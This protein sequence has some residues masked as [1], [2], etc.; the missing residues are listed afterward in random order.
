MTYNDGT[1]FQKKG[2]ALISQESIRLEALKKQ[3]LPEA[4]ALASRCMAESD[5]YRTLYPDISVDERSRLLAAQMLPTIACCAEKGSAFALWDD[6]LMVAYEYMADYGQLK[7]EAPALY[8]HIFMENPSSPS[9]REL[10]E[11]LDALLASGHRV[12]YVLGLGIAQQYRKNVS[13]LMKLLRLNKKLLAES[14][15]IAADFTNRELL[16]ICALHGPFEVRKLAENY[17]LLVKN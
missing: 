17:W 4:A 6:K 2:A 9:Q 14:E 7:M 13:V 5:Y 10:V 16:S 3:G 1:E 11:T 8:R 12:T 15:I